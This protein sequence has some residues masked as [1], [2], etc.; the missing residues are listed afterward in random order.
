[1]TGT[2]GVVVPAYRPDVEELS[3]FVRALQDVL[4]PATLRIEVDDPDHEHAGHDAICQ[5]PETE[6]ATFD[7]IEHLL[8][9]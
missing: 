1:M 5:H 2:V 4:S 9:I 8:G 3:A 7:I 6:T